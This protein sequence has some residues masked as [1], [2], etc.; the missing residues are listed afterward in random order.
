MSPSTI[1]AALNK[2]QSFHLPHNITLIGAPGSGKGTYGRL[3]SVAWNTTPIYSASQ[4]LRE[5]K[6]DIVVSSST[7]TAKT[8]TT[9]SS[10]VSDLDSG[11][12]VDCEVVSEIILSYIKAKQGENIPTT[13]IT[14]ANTEQQE[15]V[16]EQPV[17]SHFIMDGYPRT[18]QQIEIM[19]QTWPK[20][21]HVTHAVHIN[22]PDYICEA[23]ILGRRK[24]SK[25]NGEP[26][27]TNVDDGIFC[28]P[29]MRPY[30]C[31]QRICRPIMHW[32]VSRND[33][34]NP[35]IVQKRLQEYRIN[36]K[37]IL[38]YYQN[39]DSTDNDN[40]NH[41][42]TS[43]SSTTPLTRT[44]NYISITPYNGVDDF[45]DIQGSIERWLSS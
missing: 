38:D 45:L 12:L 20:E 42:S 19:K 34:M 29:P 13:T 4:I 25:C 40:I 36:E 27:I 30:S 8:T 26:N 28:L 37:R 9:S 24:C 18:R 3:L 16:D 10:I 22:I 2:L 7:T 5:S 14:T 35:T 15:P 43:T 11:T 23:K 32:Y 41:T 31:Q 44:K 1:V 39:I 21:Y 33:D 6:Q 17:H